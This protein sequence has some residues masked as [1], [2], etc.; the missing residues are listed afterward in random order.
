MRITPYQ[1]TNV[2]NPMCN[3]SAIIAINTI[4]ISNKYIR[5]SAWVTL[6]NAAMLCA[7]AI[8]MFG[9]SKNRSPNFFGHC[10]KTDKK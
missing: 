2:Y 10:N 6:T 4:H 1:G 7:I 3:C 8:D 9:S 5:Q